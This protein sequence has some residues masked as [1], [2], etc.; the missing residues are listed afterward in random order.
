ME[1]LE[2]KKVDKTWYFINM[3]VPFVLLEAAPEDGDESQGP[4]HL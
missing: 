2:K 3:Y 4:E 1:K